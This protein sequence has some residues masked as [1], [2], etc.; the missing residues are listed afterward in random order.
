MAAAALGVSLSTA[1][2]SAMVRPEPALSRAGSGPSLNPGSPSS[3]LDGVSMASATDGWAVG[4]YQNTTT[5]ILETLILHWNGAAW[6]K[7]SSPSPG[8]NGNLLAGV[9]AVS[10]ADVWAVGYQLA[11]SAS[12]SPGKTLILHWNGAAWS[13]VNSPNPGPNGNLLAGVS[14]FSSTDAWAVGYRAMRSS[15]PGDSLILHWNGTSWAKVKSPNPVTG[16]NPLNAVSATSGSDAWAVGYSQSASTSQRSALIL[17]WNGTA[18]SN[19]T[20]AR[21]GSQSTL[22]GVSATSATDAWAAG[23]YVSPPALSLTLQWD[24][25]AWSQAASPNPGRSYD[26]LTGVSADSAT[27]A[28]AV[29]YYSQPNG[30]VPH[31]TL[32]LHWDGTSWSAVKSPDPGGRLMGDNDLYGV[33]AVS[34]ADAWAVGSY[35]SH[36][37]YHTL[38]LHWNG[39][40]WSKT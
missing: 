6:S 13:K 38:I 26:I 37:T 8:P 36:G 9:S 24:G 39:A 27:D 32:T 21:P 25:T 20:S 11:S 2:A 35:Y 7:V 5:H 31:D 10:A 30:Y 22:Y 1:A 17:H 29:G 34:P 19:V 14:A 15:A 33:S 23:D 3:F 40:A 28:W 18:W 16:A 4:Y 12:S